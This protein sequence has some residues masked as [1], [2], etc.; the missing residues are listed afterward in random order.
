MAIEKDVVYNTVNGRELKADL[1][2]PEGGTV[3]TRTAVVLVHGGGWIVGDGRRDEG[4]HIGI[5]GGCQTTLF[6]F[7]VGLKEG[8]I[9]NG[10]VRTNFII[11]IERLLGGGA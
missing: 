7:Q 8:E 4:I 3:P 11:I 10:R 5:G 2:R 1:Y 6:C 9:E